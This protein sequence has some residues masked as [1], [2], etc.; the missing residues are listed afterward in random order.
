M[1]NIT[2][3]LI[4]HLKGSWYVSVF[5]WNGSRAQKHKPI[6]SQQNV[7]GF[8]CFI[9]NI[10]EWNVL[11]TRANPE[12]LW[13]DPETYQLGAKLYAFPLSSFEHGVGGAVLLWCYSALPKCWLWETGG[14]AS[15][16]IWYTRTVSAS[17]GASGA[18][19]CKEELDRGHS[20]I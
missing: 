12:L 13:K 3:C 15:W 5:Y 2:R 4:W 8:H 20:L 7:G 6:L 1:Q 9:K 18:N 10:Y 16:G 14:K 17:S 19:D 11:W